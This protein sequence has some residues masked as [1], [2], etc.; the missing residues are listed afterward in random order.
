MR[1]GQ[2]AV[3]PG[4]G[5]QGP[6]V[7]NTRPVNAALQAKDSPANMAVDQGHDKKTEE[8]REEENAA[9]LQRTN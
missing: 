7:K 4:S 6:Q 9:K 8:E 1:A 5:S 3:G 2:P